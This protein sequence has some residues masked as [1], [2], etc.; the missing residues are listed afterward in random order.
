MKH[1]KFIP[2]PEIPREPNPLLIM[3]I[4]KQAYQKILR[5]GR[6]IDL[7]NEEYACM[8]AWQASCAT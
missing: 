8:K 2:I 1:I 5:G 4:G 7:T 6:S 3:H